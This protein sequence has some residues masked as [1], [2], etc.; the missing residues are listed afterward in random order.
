MYEVP[1]EMCLRMV[2]FF[3]VPL[4]IISFQLSKASG[5]SDGQFATASGRGVCVL[6]S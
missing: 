5:F 2:L 6:A 3:T 4:F 1:L